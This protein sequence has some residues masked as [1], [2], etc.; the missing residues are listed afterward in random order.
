MK[1]DV[2]LTSL[3]DDRVGVLVDV[4][5]NLLQAPQ[6]ADAALEAALG[7]LVVGAFQPA[8]SKSTTVITLQQYRILQL[9]G[10]TNVRICTYS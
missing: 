3:T 1:T 2:M 6:T 4:L 10:C 5:E 7:A 9:R 8:A